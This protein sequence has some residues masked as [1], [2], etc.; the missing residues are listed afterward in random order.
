MA[1]V[2][3]VDVA[4]IPCSEY[5]RP[6]YYEELIRKVSMIL[7]LGEVHEPIYIIDCL[8]RNSSTTIPS[9]EFRSLKK[10][11][12]ILHDISSASMYTIKQD[13]D[14]LD[15][16]N[17]VIITSYCRRTVLQKY[18]ELLFTTLYNFE[19]ISI[20]DDLSAAGDRGT[21]AFTS[22]QVTQVSD[23]VNT[24][25]G[26]LPAI[27]EIT[28]L[29]SHLVPGCF[30]HGFTTRTGGVSYIRTL[31]SLN[32]FSSSK[33]RDPKS[34]VLENIRRLGLKVG[35]QPHQF[36]M[37][38]TDHA[39]DV[40][41]VGDDA[42]K[43]YDGIVTNQVNVVLAAPGADC[44]PLLFT[45]SVLKVIGVAHAGWK[46]TLM[47]I[48]MATVNA[49][50]SRFGSRKE[51]ILAVIGP[52]VGP[53]CFRLDQGSAKEFQ[54]IHP[55]CV[56]EDGTSRPYVNIRLATRIL[57]ERGGLCSKHIHDDTVTDIRNV[58]LCTSC[59]T[60]MFFSHVRDGTNFGTQ[61]GFLWIKGSEQ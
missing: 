40:W 46:G 49:M 22:E 41:V 31:S 58:T 38:K 26:Q 2:V 32:L 17:V 44:M 20:F 21:S 61:I 50:V 53:C 43:S 14:S 4:S 48:A 37:V 47:G 39:S 12:R 13:L 23:D 7:D 5:S 51:N 1:K 29:Q 24:F 25:V 35:F 45:D 60:D 15:L 52:S 55:D 59:H 30:S 56:R 3:V 9:D 34:I 8:H 28:V 57:L 42:P 6:N 36:H 19:Y 11:I 27:G 10:Q 54:S 18:Q 33:R 16:S